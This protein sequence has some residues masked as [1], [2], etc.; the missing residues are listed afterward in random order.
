[1]PY[2]AIPR[3]PLTSASG[4][5][6]LVLRVSEIERWEPR[7]LERKSSWEGTPVRMRLR[8]SGSSRSESHGGCAGV[9]PQCDLMPKAPEEPR[10][11]DWK[12]DAQ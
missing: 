4:V 10:R 2:C 1:M 8:G 9:R 3:Q 6:P 5:I 12:A 7:Q 11:F